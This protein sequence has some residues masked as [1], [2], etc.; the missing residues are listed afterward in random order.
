MN[1]LVAFLLFLLPLIFW[2]S[3]LKFELAKVV[4]FLGWSFLIILWL[5]KNNFQEI[6]INFKLNKK[7]LIWLGILTASTLLSQTF[8][9]GALAGG[10]RH[11]GVIFFAALTILLLVGRNLRNDD[12]KKIFRFI[13]LV[14]LI[15]SVIVCGQWLAIHLGLPILSYN[16]RPLG[17][18]GEPNAVAG[19]LVLGLPFF[20]TQFKKT[21]AWIAL[22]ALVVGAIILTGSKSGFLA[23]ITEAVVLAFLRMKNFRFKKALLLTSITLI[24]LIGILGVWLEKDQSRF[25]NRWLIWQLGVEAVGEKPILGY[26]AEGII[27]VYDLKFQQINR[28]LRDLM[29]D[30]SHNLSLDI[31]LVSGVVGLAFF[32][33]WFW[34]IIRRLINIK[35]W[36]LIPLVG[37]LVFSFFQ[38]IGVT[39]WVY[40]MFLASLSPRPGTELKKVF[41]PKG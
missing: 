24:I 13:I 11:Q 19:F 39:H 30:R 12:L 36:L 1:I 2:P 17:T 9:F 26:G 27:Q 20:I 31:T 10:Y 18:L 8:P 32:G 29:I 37:F 5:L 4:F 23:L 34:Q 14:V 16:Q 15:E 28:S 40:L 6:K 25:E 3:P 35:S 22:G 41:D 33:A 7:W 21:L 38:P